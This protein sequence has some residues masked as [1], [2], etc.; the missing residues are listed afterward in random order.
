M[1]K[2]FFFKADLTTVI[3][4]SKKFFC[5]EKRS[6]MKLEAWMADGGWCSAEDY[7]EWGMTLID[8]RE[9]AGKKP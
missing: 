3:G 9:M 5:N 1:G 6:E 2:M 4:E 8:R 7:S